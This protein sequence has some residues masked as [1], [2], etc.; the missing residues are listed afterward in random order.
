MIG[1]PIGLVFALLLVLL[2]VAC[3]GVPEVTGQPGYIYTI[4]GGGG[5]TQSA[6]DGGNARDAKFKRIADLAVSGSSLY[7]A[8]EDRVRRI[9]LDT[10]VVETFAGGGDATPAPGMNARETA[11]NPGFVATD[12]EGRVWLVCGLPDDED[13]RRRA[14]IV[15]IGGR[16]SVIER[17]VEVLPVRSF[18][19]GRDG[20]AFWISIDPSSKEWE[21]WRLGRSDDTPSVVFEYRRMD[22][23][24]A[25]GGGKILV[26]TLDA[27]RRLLSVDPETGSAEIVA[28]PFESNPIYAHDEDPPLGSYMTEFNPLK[29]AVGP[30]NNIYYTQSTRGSHVARIDPET[31]DVAV[32]A[33]AGYSDYTGDG[34][35]AMEA[36]LEQATIAF[37][38]HGNGYISQNTASAIRRINALAAPTGP[39]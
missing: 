28:G 37:D 23:L 14:M 1:Q 4:A 38:S 19:V 36:H 9:D 30:D 33:G 3:G 25:D 13:G 31:G 5:R 16:T 22:T 7:V 21:I 12:G 17:V 34:G 8:T 39:D 32:V 24:T 27:P 20:T 35:P 15:V 11:M 2:G 29:L 18:A 26:S 10:M 6:G